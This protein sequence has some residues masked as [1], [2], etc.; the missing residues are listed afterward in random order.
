MP[1]SLPIHINRDG[2]HSLDVP[3]SFETEE[4]FD[5]RL[6]NHGEATH[7]H[8]HLDDDLSKY[9]VLDAPNHH[10]D[11][12][13]ER[14][15]RVTLTEEGGTR[16][17]L[18]A[19]TAYGATTR[20]IEVLISEP[21]KTT[22]PVVVSEELGKP[23]PREEPEPESPLGGETTAVLLAIGGIGVALVVGIA[24]LVQNLL[25]AGAALAVVA[26]LLVGGYLALS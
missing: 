1:E 13:S 7:V 12:E 10:V 18:K 16:G 5:V 3:A 14:R 22:E 26:V 9:A 6:I 8:L 25:A 21:D 20:Y 24:I 4:S 19:V 2:L 23:Q 17:N 15:V 11:R